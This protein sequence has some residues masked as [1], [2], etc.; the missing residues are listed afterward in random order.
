MTGLR[1]DTTSLVVRAV[2]SDDSTA[3]DCEPFFGLG[4]DCRA[5]SGFSPGIHEAKRHL[6]GAR[7]LGPACVHPEGAHSDERSHDAV[8]CRF[9]NECP[10]VYDIDSTQRNDELNRRGRNRSVGRLRPGHAVRKAYLG[11]RAELTIHDDR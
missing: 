5:P 9:A 2:C 8:L 11:P 6:D 10:D 4:L 3:E 1:G 7:D